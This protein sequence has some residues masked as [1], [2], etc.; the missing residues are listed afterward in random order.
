MTLTK[1]TFVGAA[2]LALAACGSTPGERALSGGALGAGT[3]A[4]ID[5][6]TGAVIGGGAGAAAGALTAPRERRY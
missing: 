2:L 1:A 4:L 6:G 3:G 5:G